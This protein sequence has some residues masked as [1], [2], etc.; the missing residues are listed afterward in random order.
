MSTLDLTHFLPPDLARKARSRE[1]LTGTLSSRSPSK[2]HSRS[3]SAAGGCPVP[4]CHSPILTVSPNHVRVRRSAECAWKAF[5]IRRVMPLWVNLWKSNG[6]RSWPDRRS[7]HPAAGGPEVRG[8]GVRCS[9]RT[10][11]LG[12]VPSCKTTLLTPSAEQPLLTYPVGGMSV[13]VGALLVGRSA[14]DAITR[15][16]LVC[17]PGSRCG[18]ESPLLTPE[19]MLLLFIQEWT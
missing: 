4:A 15:P 6:Y 1:R 14:A 3:Y 18:A 16:C 8:Y 11:P 12:S 9:G 5:Y 17:C 19:P 7:H 2:P 10:Y 13:S